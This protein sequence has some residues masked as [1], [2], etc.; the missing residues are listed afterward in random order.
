MWLNSEIQCHT[1]ITDRAQIGGLWNYNYELQYQD[2]FQIII[3]QFNSSRYLGSLFI[4]LI[5]LIIWK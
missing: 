5:Y 4:A 2:N 1:L 3:R